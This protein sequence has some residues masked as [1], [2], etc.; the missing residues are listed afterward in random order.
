MERINL[1]PIYT[2]LK[3][4]LGD[5]WTEYKAALSAFVL[6]SLNQ[7]ELSWVLQPLLYPAP[8]VVASA[9]SG[10]SLV[11]TLTLHNTLLAALY[12]NTLRDAPPSDVA[13]WVVATDK[14]TSTTKNAGAGA[15]G[16]DQME[17]LLKK[18]VMGMPARERKRIKALNK[19]VKTGH[20]G[21]AEMV[22]YHRELGIKPPTQKDSQ[23]EPQSATG[24]GP[25]GGASSL[26]RTNFEVDIKKRY[27][28]RLACE[29][30][31]FPA[32]N[33]I[34][35][36]IEPICYE[37]GLLGGVQQGS[38][39]TCAE[40]IEQA[41]EVYVKEMLGNL[42]SHTRSNVAGGEG[43]YT[44]K[45]MR[46]LRKEE[47][48]VERGILQRN[49]AGMLPIEMEMQAKREP[50]D[51]QDLRL[52]LGL[53]DSYLF[54]DRHLPEQVMLNQ[55]PELDL[56]P[57]TN[58]VGF[59]AKPRINGIKKPE[60]PSVDPDAMAIDDF[61]YGGFKGVSRTDRDGLM[62]SLDECLLAAP[63]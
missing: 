39:Q 60:R 32:L 19:R 20:E 7:A 10:K 28:V 8:S 16:N 2:Q 3:A 49:A 63:G 57:N 37:E 11:S 9:D 18:E 27:A 1:E 29:N 25:S 23:T 46:Q 54:S 43:V 55:Y 5:G 15:G 40:L 4:A 33:D 47:G 30:M 45:F 42:L 17:E 41:A 51:L 44:D 53:H 31:E 22:D 13:S 34:Q 59:G 50:L 61:D 14:P 48:D 21:C 35:S 56:S 12:A 26:L 24:T 36:R 62:G 58:G 38:H 52:S 6:G